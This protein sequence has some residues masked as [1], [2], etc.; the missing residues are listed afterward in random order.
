MLSQS[1][2]STQDQLKKN[3]AAHAA[4]IRDLVKVY[5]VREKV[6]KVIIVTLLAIVAGETT[7]ILVNSLNK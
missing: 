5:E 3:E 7:Y 1:L 4:E 6:G 2:I